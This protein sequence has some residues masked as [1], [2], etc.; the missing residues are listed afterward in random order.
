MTLIN[1]AVVALAGPI[2]SGK[3]TTAALLARQLAWRQAG[4][5][6]AIRA[7]A[8]ARGEPADREVLRQLG[9]DL[10]TSGWD[11][12]TR[13]VLQH[14]RW[15]PG[16]PLILDGLRHL[17]AVPALRAAVAP[18]PVIT[19]YLDLPS[20]VAAARARHRDQDTQSTA[21]SATHPTELSLPAVRDHADVI[22]AAQSLSAVQV[23]SQIARYLTTALGH[24]PG[25]KCA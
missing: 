21:G 24:N 4:Y 20:A 9:L 19:V 2:G 17:P 3:T 6:D 7:I 23:T 12:F 8:A 11:T 10:L 13:M 14:A 1:P 15:H 18:L 22:I 5:G 25:G 16:Q